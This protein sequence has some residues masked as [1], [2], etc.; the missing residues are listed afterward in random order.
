MNAVL[1]IHGKGGAASESEHYRPLFPDHEVIGLDYRTSTPWEAG[2]EIRA[3]VEGMK[4]KYDTIVLIA[5]SIGAFF[6]MNA[7]IDK[8]IL[9]AYF[10]SPVVD[11]EK[12]IGGMMDLAGVTEA[13]LRARGVIPTGFGEALSWEYLSYVRNHPIVWEA[14]TLILYG[15]RDEV[16]SFETISGFAE[17]HRAALTVMEDGGHWF[18][19][20]EQMGFLDEWIRMENEE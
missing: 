12:L 1:Y 17:K 13:E 20:E 9:K 7:G 3:A 5:N 19:T 11:M 4:S 16:T 18:H 8:M 14:P 10:I 15:S 6:C 2:S